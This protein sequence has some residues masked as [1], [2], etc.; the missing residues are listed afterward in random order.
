VPVLGAPLRQ[1]LAPELDSSADLGIDLD[2]PAPGHE[3]GAELVPVAVADGR[4][5][6]VADHDDPVAVDLAADR[7]RR[8]EALRLA[9]GR[10]AVVRGRR[11]RG[12]RPA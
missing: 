1:H 10:P 5:H 7:P 6:R 8:V 9:G 4:E 11:V 12:R 3:I 2:D